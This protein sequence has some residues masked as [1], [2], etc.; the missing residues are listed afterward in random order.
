MFHPAP[1]TYVFLMI[2]FMEVALGVYVLNRGKRLLVN[3]T[4]MLLALL[5]AVGSLLNMILVSLTQVDEAS[6]VAKA[7]ILFIVIELGTA[8]YLNMI[9]IYDQRT[10]FFK[11]HLPIYALI[12]LIIASILAL[13]VPSISRDEIGWIFQA[14]WPMTILVVLL[15][16]YV[17]MVVVAQVRKFNHLQNKERRVQSLIYTFALTFPANFTLFILALY[18]WGFQTPRLNGLG[19]LLSIVLMSYCIVHYH[20]FSTDLV[21]EEVVKVTKRTSPLHSGRAYLIES[22]NLEHMF[23]LLLQEMEIGTPALIICRTHPDQLRARYQLLKTPLIWLAQSPGPDRIDPGNLQLLTHFTLEFM[24]KG[25]L[26]IAIE[27]LEFLLVNNELTGV[28]RFIGQLRDH[29]IMEDAIL[30]LTVDPRTLTE[31]QKA[32]LERELELVE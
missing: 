27:G 2:T 1:L 14:S 21:Q 10:N 26:I 20:L 18:T 29:V 8:Y 23:E 30:L 22:P 24:R 25:H 31:K 16:T 5:A 28:L 19:E 13:N 3:R 32:I 17:V 9:V 4:F 7:M 11:K 6:I 12:I 15:I